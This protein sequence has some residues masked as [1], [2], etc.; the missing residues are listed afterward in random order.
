ME[1]RRNFGE[2]SCPVCKMSLHPVDM[3]SHLLSEVEQLMCLSRMHRNQQQRR[4]EPLASS[5]STDSSSNTN[6]KEGPAE[7]SQ[8]SRWETYQR[9]RVNRHSRLRLKTRRRR[10][11][12]GGAGGPHVTCPVCQIPL[13]GPAEQLSGHVEACLRKDG[14]YHNGD[15]L[16]EDEPVDIEGD[17]D[18]DGHDLDEYDWMRSRRHLRPLVDS[19]S[20]YPSKF[21]IKFKY[22]ASLSTHHI[23][24]T[25]TTGILVTA[26]NMT[27]SRRREEENDTMEVVVDGDDTSTYGYTQYTEADIHAAMNRTESRSP[28]PARNQDGNSDGSRWDDRESPVN[29]SCASDDG[30]A[31]Q[32]GGN[33]NH[34]MVISALKHRVRELERESKS[35]NQ[36]GGNHCLVCKDKYKKPVV[37]I[38]CWHVHCEQCWL[39]SLG[40]KKLCPQC[41][42]ITSAADLRRVFF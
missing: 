40:S 22:D 32:L 34:K 25:K 16:D 10:E 21:F 20:N 7:L 27:T 1:R 6:K 4:D 8:D 30:S 38:S 39:R 5:S 24:M 28:T 3:E 19:S 35:D 36:N 29:S 13:Q 17:G 12:S 41:N 37:S 14:R 11:E 18:G 9:V 15:M 26:L 23:P 31:D 33:V 2:L 42:M